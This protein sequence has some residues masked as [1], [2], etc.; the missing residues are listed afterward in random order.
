MFDNRVEDQNLNKP[1]QDSYD[2]LSALNSSSFNNVTLSTE[3]EARG[4]KNIPA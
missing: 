1:G 2:K 4:I 3:V